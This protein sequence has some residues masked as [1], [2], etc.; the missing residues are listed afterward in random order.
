MITHRYIKSRWL[1][2]SLLSVL[3]VIT[4]GA[5]RSRGSEGLT[6]V[7]SFEPLMPATL[8]VTVP[9]QTAK[10][11]MKTDT[12]GPF[13]TTRATDIPATPIVP[14]EIT[15]AYT[16]TPVPPLVVIPQPPEFPIMGIEINN[17][18]DI[19][20]A[21]QA[22]A[23]WIRRN[24]LLWSVVEPSEG[25]RNWGAV[26]SFERELESISSNGMQAI[27]IVSGTPSWAQ[28]LMGVHCGP[29]RAE[30]LQAFATFVK[31]A[32][33]RYS[34]P[35]FNVMYWEIWN[36]PDVDPA[37]VASDAQFGCWGD[38]DDAYYGGGY[39]AEM[40]KVVYPAIKAANPE[41]QVLVGGLLLHCDPVNPPEVKEQPGEKKDCS[42]AKFLEGILRNG[43]G[44]YFD[45]ISFHAYDYYY[46]ILGNYGNDLWNSS[47]KTTGPALLAKTTYIKTLLAYYDFSDKYLMNSEVAGLCGNTGNEPVCYQEDWVNT[48]VYHM[49]ETYASAA[50]VGLRANIW[51][52]LSGW[53]GSGL[54][55]MYR[56]PEP[57]YQA[58]QF[59]GRMLTGA[60]PQ[61]EITL[62]R[63][64][65]GFA[66]QRGGKLLWVLWS[67]NGQEHSIPL[68][69]QP[70]AI[71]NVFGEG[72]KPEA[73]ITITLSPIYIEW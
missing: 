57:A 20:M 10:P 23:Y 69:V 44:N 49:V 70:N 42:P 53:R 41:A 43:G 30:K 3:I 7:R 19:E 56:E 35:P 51:Y 63:G 73:Y 25:T 47:W 62:Y 28:K 8:T 68:G 16:A 26:A 12:A 2:L 31:D 36:E 34:Q 64:V 65:K 67:L 11:D 71:Y 5:C 48:K 27:L 45:G 58:Y 66:F 38:P 46:N 18:N 1:G 40:L 14:S 6:Q 15:A 9:V 59:I 32:V 39:Y 4:F 24:A 55:N 60:I 50:I 22:G 72:Q 61:G 13:V 33:E 17:I 37:L 52:S 21:A 29:I 54:I